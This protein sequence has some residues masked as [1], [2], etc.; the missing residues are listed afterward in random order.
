MEGQWN[1]LKEFHAGKSNEIEALSLVPTDSPWFPGH[2]PGEPI[3]PG[4]ALIHTVQQVILQNA[5]KSNENVRLDALRRIR[6]VQPVKPGETL[7]LNISREDAGNEIL[8]S[9]KIANKENIIVCSGLIIAKFI[10]P[11]GEEE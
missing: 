1:L 11:K 6:F 3:L 8:F 7:K 2:F 10:N 9:F 4:I 5:K